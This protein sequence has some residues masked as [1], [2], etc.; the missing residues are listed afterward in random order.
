MDL[1]FFSV[2]ATSSRTHKVNTE[3]SGL[4]LGVL[5]FSRPHSDHL[6]H[7]RLHSSDGAFDAPMGARGDL[8]GDS[9]MVPEVSGDS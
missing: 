1:S 3:D 6:V 4:L 7:D 9:S 5:E 8:R 2:T